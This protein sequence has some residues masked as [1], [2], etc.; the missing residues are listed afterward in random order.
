VT[1][2]AVEQHSGDVLAKLRNVLLELDD[3][4][5]I[6]EDSVAVYRAGASCPNLMQR[7]PMRTCFS[8]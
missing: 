6:E 1:G 5:E 7:S 2:I 4:E 3:I 8:T